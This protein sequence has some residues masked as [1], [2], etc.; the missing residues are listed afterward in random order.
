MQVTP[1]AKAI[2]DNCGSGTRGSKASPARILLQG[3]LG[4]TGKVA[5]PPVDQGFE[6]G[7]ARS[8]ARWRCWPGP[9]SSTG[10][11]AR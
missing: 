10:S 4:G 7:S 9:S 8:F 6:H 1:A 5:T 11:K 2:L 3:K